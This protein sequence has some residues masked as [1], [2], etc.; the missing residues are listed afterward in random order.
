MLHVDPMQPMCCA[1]LGIALMRRVFATLALAFAALPAAAAD[2]SAPAPVL[3]GAL[4]VAES[5]V[6]WTG[7][8]FGATGSYGSLSLN[9]NR[10]IGQVDELLDRLVRGSVIQPG[11][12]AMPLVE[13]GK[14]ETN[15]MG[16]GLFAGYN[17]ATDGAI[18]GFEA[19]YTRMRFEN[20][21]SGERSGRV[22][23]G[24]TTY[25]W[26][27]NTERRSKLTDVATFRGRIGYAMGNFLPF[28]TG[29][30]AVGR[31]AEQ[32]SARIE[33]VQFA[34]LAG[35]CA[36]DPFCGATAYPAPI[37]EGNRAKFQFGY[38]VGAGVDIALSSNIFVR[39]ELQ[40][41]RLPE[42]AGSVAQMNT[43]RVGAAVKY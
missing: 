3:R 41:I 34:T 30:L 26:N 43:A 24:A 4:P 1:V 23:S 18:F 10:Q 33:G 8:Y 9:R 25:D 7:F 17:F 42:L 38:T 20:T 12:Y 11:V 19:D 27:A 13:R 21:V 16:L 15:S 31:S 29:G 39:A 37:V 35:T 6:D 36:A 28:V 32:R 22:S 5:G 14:Y 40:H 2:M